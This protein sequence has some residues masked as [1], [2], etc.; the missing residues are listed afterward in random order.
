MFLALIAINLVLDAQSVL[1]SSF[2]EQG[3]LKQ[4]DDFLLGWESGRGVDSYRLKRDPELASD[5]AHQR[6]GPGRRAQI[7][8]Q[9]A[10]IVQELAAISSNPDRQDPGLAKT[11][12][13]IRNDDQDLPRSHP[14]TRW[15]GGVIIPHSQAPMMGSP[16]HLQFA[17]RPSFPAGSQEDRGGAQPAHPILRRSENRG[18]QK[19]QPEGALSSTPNPSSLGDGPRWKE[20]KVQKKLA[21]P[22]GANDADQQLRSQFGQVKDIPRVTELEKLRARQNLGDWKYNQKTFEWAECM[23][24]CGEQTKETTIRSPVWMAWWQLV[25]RHRLC[26]RKCE[27]KDGRRG[28]GRKSFEFGKSWLRC[29]DQCGLMIAYRQPEGTIDVDAEETYWECRNTI[30]SRLERKN[31]DY[32]YQPTVNTRERVI[33]KPEWGL[34]GSQAQ[35]AAGGAKGKVQQFASRLERVPDRLDSV[36]RQIPQAVNSIIGA[37]SQVKVPVGGL[38]RGARV[39]KYVGV[40]I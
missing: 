10:A 31:N 16:G 15:R 22:P 2:D 4:N 9:A 30:C 18:R 38:L 11:P 8:A 27:H 19:P 33:G 28:G 40:G 1:C 14:E 6:P 21:P 39:P 26:N 34:Q 37:A 25:M 5:S 24:E 23:D 20:E 17:G 12:P 36:M 3:F 35:E 7:P 32:V 13:L 29:M